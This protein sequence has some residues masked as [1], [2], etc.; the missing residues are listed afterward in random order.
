MMESRQNEEK[1]FVEEAGIIF[2]QTGL[3][4]M[5]G[6]IFGQ[7]LI[8]DPTHQSSAE[9]SEALMASKGAISTMTRFLIQLGLIERFAVPGKRQ[10]Y[11]RLRPDALRRTIR[12]GL[13]EEVKMYRQLAEHGLNLMR[14]KGSPSQQW[15]K[16]MHERYT[17]LEQEL[18]LLM[19]RWEKQHP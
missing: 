3:P 8:A 2:E 9:L 18:P 12:H 5:A 13:E 19:K 4:R 15:L 1:G 11:F 14:G 6:R 17:F 16:E 10:T 7:L